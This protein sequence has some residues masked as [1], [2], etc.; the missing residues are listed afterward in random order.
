[1]AY[2]SEEN[3]ES[4]VQGDNHFPSPAGHT[5]SYSSQDAVGLPGHPSTLLDHIQPTSH[6]Y[7]QV[8]LRL[9]A[10]QP[11]I[12]QPVAVLGVIAPQV[13]DPAL[14]LVKKKKQQT[15]TIYLKIHEGQ[16]C[17]WTVSHTKTLQQR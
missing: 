12:S 1:V 15:V 7:S 10:L 5:A 3:L 17:L 13:Q 8:L 16:K 11:L 4:R 14:S 9:A 2:P 6:Q